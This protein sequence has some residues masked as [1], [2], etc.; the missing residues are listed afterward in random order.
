MDRA[1]AHL[2]EA[3]P[4]T[5]LEE[6]DWL[7]RA[8]LHEE[9]LLPWVEEFR[10]RRARREAHPVRDFLFT[11]YQTNRR[12]LLRWRPSAGEALAGDAANR[13]LNEPSYL[14]DEYGVRLDASKLVGARRESVGWARRLLESAASR[15]PRFG[16]FGLHEWAML[17]RA[18]AAPR[19]GAPLRVDAR[20]LEATVE[21]LPIR[22]T[23]H[24]AFRFFTPAAA[25]LNLARPA[26]EDRE[27]FEQFGCVH[28]NMDLY[29]W[30]YK[31]SPWIGAD[32]M[33][34]CFFLA[35]D[36]REIDMRASPYDLTGYGC[37]PI[38]VE[39]PE[40]RDAYAAEQRRIF[41]RGQPLAARF[42]E[43]CDLLLDGAAR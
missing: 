33:R 32:L 2:R 35:A 1:G 11:Y 31:L 21:S 18:E 38:R 36:A 15:A 19:E 40:G 13:Y 8:R 27:R 3:A 12:A 9:A 14:R 17:Y 5:V 4:P 42:R 29:R 30:C 37:E 10:E 43:E 28:F 24:D 34:D 6:A 26:R 22:C 16:C 25:P 39:T 7:E 23:H 20:T 41:E